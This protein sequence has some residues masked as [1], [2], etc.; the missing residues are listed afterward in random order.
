MLGY[1]PSHD[2]PAD[3]GRSHAFGSFPIRAQRPLQPLT[4]S[5]QWTHFLMRKGNDKSQAVPAPET[6]RSE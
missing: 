1:R 2:S 3:G 4:R 6:P 5:P